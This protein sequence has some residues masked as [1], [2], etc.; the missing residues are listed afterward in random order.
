MSEALRALEA[1]AEIR[2]LARVLGEPAERLGFLAEVPPGDIQALRERAT[3]VLFDANVAVLRRM[4][5]ASRLLPASVLAR[6]AEKVFGPLL[7][8][9]IAGLVDAH[10]GVEIASHLPA[11]FL[12]DVAAELDPRRASA[13][14]AGIPTSTVGA[15]ARELA[16]REDWITVGRFVGHVP[17]EAVAASIDVLDDAAVLR[18]AFVLDDKSR[19]PAVLRL[20]PATRLDGVVRAAVREGLWAEA[21]DV[22]LRLEPPL[23]GDLAAAV[24]A[25]PATDRERAAAKARALGLLD[26]L[27]PARDA[28]LS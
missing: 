26:E 21:F 6:I 15:V 18:V 22:L 14:L 20:L 3:T 7:C 2:K 24:A 10:R 8:A 13:V 17:A 9:R 5:A 12:A 16:R 23:A 11:P 1:Q 19:L 4:A 25:L 28:L 27:G